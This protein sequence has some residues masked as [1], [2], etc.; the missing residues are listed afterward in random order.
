MKRAVKKTYTPQ[1]GS[2]TDIAAQSTTD[3]RRKAK[4]KKKRGVDLVE[5][6]SETFDKTEPVTGS[7]S[8]SASLYD[9]QSELSGEQ[10]Y[11]DVS[12]SDED[13]S[14]HEGSMSGTDTEIEDIL[15]EHG[16]SILGQSTESLQMRKAKSK[17]KTQ[18]KQSGRQDSV[19]EE[20]L[21][22]HGEPLP[23]ESAEVRR[24]RKGKEEEFLDEHAEPI[25]RRVRKGKGKDKKQRKEKERDM[26]KSEMGSPLLD[27]DEYLE[28]EHDDSGEDSKTFRRQRKKIVKQWR[29]GRR[30][31]VGSSVASSYLE[32][33]NKYYSDSSAI[34]EELERDEH[35]E[36]KQK[37][38]YRRTS[39]RKASITS[40]GRSDSITSGGREKERRRSSGVKDKRSSI[41]IPSSAFVREEQGED[42]FMQY[43][44]GEQVIIVFNHLS[45]LLPWN[46]YKSQTI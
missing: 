43:E 17:D 6:K 16:E 7:P 11:R 21:D 3:T 33:K 42:I 35:G 19:I 40:S 9:L 32:E 45:K 10:P 37:S 27:D 8:L 13:L 34:T 12:S 23:G 15:D 30:S 26:E 2:P 14:E 44:D 4:G 39:I 22:E 36:Q 20:F 24:V 41:Q 18:R 31:S 1:H 5:S 29:E 25:H 38:Q 46:Y 28:Y